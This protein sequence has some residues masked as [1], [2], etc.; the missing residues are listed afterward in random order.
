MTHSLRLLSA[1]EPEL[2]ESR[3]DDLLSASP[4]HVAPLQSEVQPV[5]Q[6]DRGQDT[7]LATRL[8]VLEYRDRFRKLLRLQYP[9]LVDPQQVHQKL[10]EEAPRLLEKRVK[11]SRLF[12][13]LTPK[14][15]HLVNR[16]GAG[17]ERKDP[18]R[19]E[20]LNRQFSLFLYRELPPQY[21]YK[22][23]VY[24]LETSL[25]HFFSQSR[26]LVQPRESRLIH[27]SQLVVF[28]QR[29]K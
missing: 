4:Y 25:N 19:C 7:P 29:H 10:V 17:E 8:R 27:L 21:C 20:H 3:V 2:E 11:E 18:V 28:G 6:R 13:L 22:V 16:Y 26:A 9:F 12:S 24:V 14:Q 5:Q 1:R 23:L 15:Y